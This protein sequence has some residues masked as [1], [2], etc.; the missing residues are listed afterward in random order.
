[1]LSRVRIFM[2][3]SVKIFFVKWLFPVTLFVFFAGIDNVFSSELKKEGC[4]VTPIPKNKAAFV[5]IDTL[6]KII[7]DSVR[8]CSDKEDNLVTLMNSKIAFKI[9]KVSKKM[10]P[11]TEK[12]NHINLCAVGRTEGFDWANLPLISKTKVSGNKDSVMSE[13]LQVDYSSVKVL[14]STPDSSM[15]MTQGK[16]ADLPFEVTNIYSIFPEKNW[17]KVT[18]TIYNT[19]SDT[20]RCWIGDAME[21]DYD[22][23]TSIFPNS[24][25]SVQMVVNKEL[26]LQEFHPVSPWMGSFNASDQVF[27]VFYE[28]D[29]AKDFEV[30]A[31]TN[32]IVSQ[33][34]MAI[35][36][37]ESV[38]FTRKLSAV[39]VTP[40]ESKLEAINKAYSAV[41]YGDGI[42]TSIATPLNV[43]NVGTTFT[44]TVT[45]N[46]LS[47]TTTYDQVLVIIKPPITIT[48]TLD[49]IVIPTMLP[50]Q[51]L[52]V[53]FELT[54][55]EGSGNCLVNVETKTSTR[56]MS[57]SDMRLFVSGKG[58]YSGDNH[59][60]SI[61]SDGTSTIE[62]NV[63]QAKMKGLSFLS[64][65]DHNTVNQ[66]ATVI[67]LKSS[68]FLPIVGTEVTTLA[69]HALALF[70]DVFVPWE[71]LSTSTLADAQNIINTIN[72]SKNGTA[73][74][75]IAHPYLATVTWKWTDVI[76]M[77]GYEVFN[78]FMPYRSNETLLAFQLWDEKLKAGAR[79]YGFAE[80]DAHIKEMVG[81]LKVC[82]LAADLKEN[83]VYDAIKSGRFYGTNGPDLRFSI[84]TVQMG[85]SLYTV[86]K[87]SVN[88][89]LTAYSCE[90]LDSVRLIKNGK[91]FKSFKYLDYKRKSEIQLYDE[92][93]PGDYFR[94]E[95][96]DKLDQ[97]A[98]SNPIF[99]SNGV[100][101]KPGKDTA[102]VIKD[103]G[104]FLSPNPATDFVKIN[105]KD[106]TSGILRIIDEI[107]IV[108][109]QEAIENK[110]EHE[111]YF[112]HLLNGL[113]VVQINRIRLK[114]MIR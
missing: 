34:R 102:D 79:V 13:S 15:V 94:M 30:S 9:E 84:D 99:I 74:S 33:K 63:N 39:S 8:L 114:L 67:G 70:C 111:M 76:N 31:N 14:Q 107:G 62:E 35:P 91:L 64:S 85:D 96:N 32:R 89:Q 58:W 103:L 57:Q 80:S 21:E 87:K 46:N 26:A 109:Y 101:T 55:V 10:E 66:K 45:L 73:I 100:A 65:T 54:A 112:P 7:I 97:V 108:R 38:S 42:E 53:N 56:S 75:V 11:T 6:R 29:F 36:P 19:S 4:K 23:Q 49:T 90:G 92:V 40:N 78:G 105:F 51:T 83:A 82:I 71:P 88:I 17:L 61:F 50:N 16:C 86:S 104:N 110:M 59:T 60:H 44:A 72:K 113:Y 68:Y 27:G 77:N 24:N 2:K 43:L 28:G 37:H 25:T 5:G 95:V 1:M 22:G 69:G 81:R 52:T 48:S 12:G 106:Y 18:S 20:V 98:F 47:Q 3:R 41:T 93:V